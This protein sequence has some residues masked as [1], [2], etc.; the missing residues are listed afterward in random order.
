M[1]YTVLHHQ[2]NISG[3]SKVFPICAFVG[4]EEIIDEWGGFTVQ[5]INAIEE[6]IF[7]LYH[8][9]EAGNFLDTYTTIRIKLQFCLGDHHLASRF[10]GASSSSSTYPSYYSNLHRDEVQDSITCSHTRYT[11]QEFE[12]DREEFNSIMKL[13]YAT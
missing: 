4:G 5:F 9:D 11:L 10:V 6:T 2:F 1:I 8:K 13:V 7:K 12:T 3:H